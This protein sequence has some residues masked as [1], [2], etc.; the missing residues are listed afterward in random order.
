VMF[1][2]PFGPQSMAT[3]DRVFAEARANPKP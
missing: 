2:A 3:T 1:Y